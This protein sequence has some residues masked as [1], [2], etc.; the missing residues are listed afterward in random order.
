MTTQALAITPTKIQAPGGAYV[1]DPAKA[2]LVMGGSDFDGSPQCPGATIVVHA[3]GDRTNSQLIFTEVTFPPGQRPWF[4]THHGEDEGF[5]VLEG[6]LTL[7]VISETGERHAM[8]TNPGELV[9]GPKDCPHSYHITSDTPC[10][11]II[12]LTPGSPLV[13][14]FAAAQNLQLDHTDPVAVAAF[15]EET[16]RLYGL[17]FFPHIP[18]D[19]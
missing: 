10:K 14:F 5:Y 2:T 19:A 4:H 11:T 1:S 16:N 18:L 7:T 9:W 3:L 12:V 6:Q 17:E 13:G 15:V 8:V